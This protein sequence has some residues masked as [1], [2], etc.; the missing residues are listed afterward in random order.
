MARLQAYFGEQADECGRCDRCL[1][2]RH[3]DAKPAEA[4]LAFLKR[5]SPASVAELVAALRPL[6]ER[7][8]VQA[9]R[10]LIDGGRVRREAD[11]RVSFRP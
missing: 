8:A 10:W 1:E 11:D 9:L 2:R 4:V 6:P 5:Q 3:T 7:E